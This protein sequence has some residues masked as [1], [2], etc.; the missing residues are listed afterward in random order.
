[1]API[2]N[3]NKQNYTEEECVYSFGD[4]CFV[5]TERNSSR[6]L[7]ASGSSQHI[8]SCCSA[9]EVLIEA[10]APTECLIPRCSSCNLFENDKKIRKPLMNKTQFSPGVGKKYMCD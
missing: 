6:S 10:G 7:Q 4:I 2:F 3:K 9:N 5:R 8:Y 1:M